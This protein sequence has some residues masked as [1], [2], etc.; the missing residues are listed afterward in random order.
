MSF[1]ITLAFA[2]MSELAISVLVD[3]N[4]IKFKSAVFEG[5][6]NGPENG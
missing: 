2:T 1:N 4:Y 3:N 6:L 5:L